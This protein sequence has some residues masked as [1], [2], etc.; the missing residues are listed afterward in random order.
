MRTLGRLSLEALP[1]PKVSESNTFRLLFH[2]FPKKLSE[3]S[4]VSPFPMKP[5]LPSNYFWRCKIWLE[6]EK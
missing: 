3:R 4:R 5:L 1:E 2:P 6:K